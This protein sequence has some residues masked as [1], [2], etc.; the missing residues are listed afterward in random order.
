MGVAKKNF[1]YT[2][3]SGLGKMSGLFTKEDENDDTGKT[4]QKDILVSNIPK[5][6]VRYG[7]AQ[8]PFYYFDSLERYFHN[9]ES[10]S[11]FIESKDYLGGLEI[12]LNGTKARLEEIT[13]FDF[14]MAIQGLLQTIESEI[15]FN[16]TEFEGSSYIKE[17]AHKVFKDKEIKV[18]KGSERAEGQ[19]DVVSE[20]DWYVYNANY[21]TSEE[22]EFVKM[23]ARRF[24][25]LDKKFKNIYLIRNEAGLLSQTLF[26][27]TY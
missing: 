19:F 6:I 23:F 10:L 24:E 27:K 20:P 11:N 2:L 21:G 9:I 17:Y 22:K 16:L 1:S 25:H 15:K 18:Y 4:S 8:N 13:P 26:C 14:L 3:S 12:T 5:H 7:L